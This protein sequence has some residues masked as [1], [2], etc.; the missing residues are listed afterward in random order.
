MTILIIIIIFSILI[1]VH[2]F[3]HFLA[4]KQ[5]GVRVEKFAIGFGPPIIRIKG[6][7]T[8]FLICLFPLGGFVKLAGDERRQCKGF[9][10]EFFS[11]PIGVR[12]RIVFFGPL[13]NIL[14]AFIIFWMIFIFAGFPSSKPIVGEVIKYGSVAKDK[15]SQEQFQILKKNKLIKEIDNDK[16]YALW[17]I[18]G[19][20][21]EALKSAELTDNDIKWLFGIWQGSAKITPKRK[22]SEAQLKKLLIYK[23][24][25]EKVVYWTI[26]NKEEL[27]AK[28][29]Q[30]RISY[31]KNILTILDESRYPAYRAGIKKGDKILEVNGQSVENW[32]QMSSLIRKS[33]D[34]VNLTILRDD[35]RKDITVI[36]ERIVIKD[37]SGK[38][39]IALIGI[40]SEIEK[41]NV[42][43]CFFQASAKLYHSG[44]NFIKG[45]YSLITKKVSFKEAV[46]GPIAIGFMTSEVAKLGIVALFRF[47][48]LLS[49]MLAIINLFPF[50]VLDGGHLLF[51]GIEKIRRKPLSLKW[52]NILTQIAIVLLAS[53]MLFVSYNDILRF[54]IKK[55]KF[56]QVQFQMLE[57]KGV[58]R[59]LSD[60]AK[61]VFWTTLKKD[62]LV[63]Q[64]AEIKDLN[65]QAI[66]T[67]WQESPKVTEVKVDKEN[68]KNR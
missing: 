63:S 61:Y 54:A 33:K 48:A 34:E 35:D 2:E 11:K 68:R 38:K 55:S 57:E 39:E 66:L 62:K 12:A 6:K 13:F 37:V 56:N 31:T 40:G 43:L 65:S 60:D 27:K 17:I 10:Y 8:Q 44:E 51:M 53:L 15:F 24:I 47:V 30:A 3:G 58:V 14:L 26:D 7:E 23:L 32:N 52:E 64:L 36:P 18:S 49:V 28:L 21:K 42:A 41:A 46:G 1:V 67:I 29:S 50:P 19:T 16:K 45:L 9:N 22:F 25:D 59:K 20:D 5:A 4:A